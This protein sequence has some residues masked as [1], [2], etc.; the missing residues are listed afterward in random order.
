MTCFLTKNLKWAYAVYNVIPTEENDIRS[1]L[2]TS[3]HVPDI[4][5]T[6]TVVDCATHAL[7][8]SC[9]NAHWVQ[10]LQHHE[11]HECHVTHGAGAF[12]TADASLSDSH[13]VHL[14]VG[15]TYSA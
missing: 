7:K 6:M 8:L 3:I 14:H 15:R 2:I 11:P 1:Q 12:V 4:V 5:W 10:L 13:P 9:Y